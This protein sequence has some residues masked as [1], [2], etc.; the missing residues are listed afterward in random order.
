M[1][2]MQRQPLRDH[3][4]RSGTTIHGWPSVALGLG[5]AAIGVVMLLLAAGIIPS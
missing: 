1:P 3:D 4:N 5:V 2:D